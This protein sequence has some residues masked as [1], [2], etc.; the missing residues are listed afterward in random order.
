M[1]RHPRTRRCGGA[2]RRRWTAAWMSATGGGTRQRSCAAV[3]RSRRRPP[4]PPGL[5][6]RSAGMPQV[7]FPRCQPEKPATP[8][9]VAARSLA[10]ARSRCRARALQSSLAAGP[11]PRTPPTFGSRPAVWRHAPAPP[12]TPSGVRGR[13]GTGRPGATAPPLDQRR[14]A[15]HALVTVGAARKKPAAR[16]RRRRPEAAP[17]SPGERCLSGRR[18]SGLR[19]RVLQPR[20]IQQHEPATET[21]FGCSTTSSCMPSPPFRSSMGM[22]ISPHEGRGCQEALQARA[23]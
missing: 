2:E 18:R 11:V 9:K 21:T 22:P 14:H 13:G 17:P 15:A 23:R 3:R 16:V 12:Q 6:K 1:R 20:R 8:A 5:R 7:S 19:P 10:A 4:R